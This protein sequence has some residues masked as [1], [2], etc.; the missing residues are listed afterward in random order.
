MQIATI[1]NLTMKNVTKICAK[2]FLKIIV[3]GSGIY[4]QKP[5]YRE[6]YAYH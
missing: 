2:S 4:Y 1:N 6:R 5:E 3:R